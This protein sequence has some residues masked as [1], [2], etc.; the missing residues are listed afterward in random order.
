MWEPALL[1]A[2]AERLGE[3]QRR[4]E[5]VANAGIDPVSGELLRDADPDPVQVLAG[6]SLDLP[7]ELQ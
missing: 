2:R 1:D 3:P 7:R 5:A 6:R 4:L